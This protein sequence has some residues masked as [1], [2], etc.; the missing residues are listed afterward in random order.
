MMLMWAEHNVSTKLLTFPSAQWY[1]G[2]LEQCWRIF[3]GGVFDKRDGM[4]FAARRHEDSNVHRRGDSKT[5]T[6]NIGVGSFFKNKKIK[7]RPNP[8]AVEAGHPAFSGKIWT[9]ES[10]EGETSSAVWLLMMKI[11]PDVSDRWSPMIENESSSRKIGTSCFAL[12][13]MLSD[14]RLDEL[15]RPKPLPEILTAQSGRTSDP[16]VDAP[17]RPDAWSTLTATASRRIDVPIAIGMTIFVVLLKTRVFPEFFV[18]KT[19]ELRS[20]VCDKNE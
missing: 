11:S 10:A 3:F 17:T 4:L 6:K 13:T 7:E 15:T 1:R 20:E 19:F 12:L 18:E 2:S 8:P 14:N 5:M 9:A 16:L